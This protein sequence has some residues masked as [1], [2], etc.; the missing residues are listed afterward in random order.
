MT[1]DTGTLTAVLKEFL[2][3]FK[4]G[5]AAIS[6]DA[7]SLLSILAAIELTLAGLL[8]AVSGSD[9]INSLF[10]KILLISFFV[11]IIDNY[12][13]LLRTVIEGFI[14]TGKT[15]A[16]GSVDVFASFQDPS[17]II[18]IGFRAT[19][20]IVVHMQ[21]LSLFPPPIVDIVLSTFALFLILG[22]FFIIAIQVFVTYLEFAM[23]STLALIFI[24][25]GVFQHTA[26]LTEKTFGAVISFG[27]K[28]MVL[29][30]VVSVA[31]PLLKTLELPPDPSFAQLFQMIIVCL[32]IAGLSWHAPSLAAGLLAGGPVLSAHS[33]LHTAT[34]GVAAG[35]AA[36]V[37]AVSA[38]RVA[39]QVSGI[40]SSAAGFGLGKIAG[41]AEVH[42]ARLAIKNGATADSI[43]PAP[44]PSPAR[45]ALTTK[46]I[47]AGAASSVFQSAAQAT[48][49]PA[50][51]GYAAG[52]E[53]APAY[54]SLKLEREA[55]AKR[56]S[57]A[58]TEKGGELSPTNIVPITKSHRT[59]HSEQS[60]KAAE[61]SN[62]PELKI[63]NAPLPQSTEDKAT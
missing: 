59:V 13:T 57:S 16:T 19:T 62:E 33:A 47:V 60:P 5:Q 32:A 58:A 9:A 35:T 23:I 4:L 40:V 28:L 53:S 38:P 63:A 21:T 25:F 20:P 37:G 36:A 27:V 55:E 42:A 22:A 61:S 14:Y 48:V 46:S 51:A 26:F 31:M 24:P 12:E 54:L 3:I 56:K 1:P 10:R 30:L 15:A 43:P 18:D 17:S 49:G 44:P 52:K 34:T 7:F 50:Q 8:W 6:H 2:S 29:G 39:S 41:N 11:F 45:Q